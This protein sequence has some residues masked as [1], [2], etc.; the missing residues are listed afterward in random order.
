MEVSFNA[1]QKAVADRISG[2]ELQCNAVISHLREENVRLR[3]ELAQA[4][5]A[6]LPKDADP[7]SIVE[8]MENKLDSLLVM[9]RT[10]TSDL[11]S[12]AGAGKQD[13]NFMPATPSPRESSVQSL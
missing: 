5:T 1:L 3:K 13:A 6:D 7:G 2:L 10:L 12:E 9:Q 8:V 4:Q 11:L